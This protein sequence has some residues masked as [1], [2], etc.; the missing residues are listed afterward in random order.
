MSIESFNVKI[1][2]HSNLQYFAALQHSTTALE[3]ISIEFSK[4][5][6]EK[7]ENYKS[8]KFYSFI[9]ELDNFQH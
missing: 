1:H 2:Q 5:F 8:A 7:S 6:I 3:K 9:V 4:H